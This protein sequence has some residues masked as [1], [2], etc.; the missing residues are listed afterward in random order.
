MGLLEPT[1]GQILLGG[2]PLGPHNRQSWQAQIAHVPRPS[3]SPTTAYAAN[4]A[5]GAAAGEIDPER[6]GTRRGGRTL[7]TSSRRFPQDMTRMSARA[8]RSGCRGGQRQRIGI[9]RALYKRAK[10]LVL[11]E[12]TSALDDATEASVME[13]IEKLDRDLTIVLIAHTHFHAGCL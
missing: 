9:A 10:V 6:V 11:D 5:F 3:F 4:I 12:A 8:R 7:A 1:S 2:E 13:A